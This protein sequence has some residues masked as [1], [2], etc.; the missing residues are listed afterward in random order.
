VAPPLAV[1]AAGSVKDASCGRHPLR[2]GDFEGARGRLAAR[3]GG[4]EGPGAPRSLPGCASLARTAAQH[5]TDS[6]PPS[7]RQRRSARRTGGLGPG[8]Q[9][10]RYIILER[11]A[12]AAWPRS[13]PRSTRTS[14]ARSAGRSC[15]PTCRRA[16]PHRGRSQLLAGPRR[17]HPLAPDVVARLRPSASSATGLDRHGVV[18]GVTSRPGSRRASRLARGAAEVRRAGR[19]ARPRTAPAGSTATS[20]RSTCSWQRRRLRVGGL[21][22]CALGGG[23]GPERAL[24]TDEPATA[25]QTT[26][27]PGRPRHVAEQH[28]GQV[29]LDARSDQY[30]FLHLALRGAPPLAPGV[31]GGTLPEDA[32]AG[33][34]PRVRS[35]AEVRRPAW[36]HRAVVAGSR[37]RPRDRYPSMD[38]LI[39]ELEKD[40]AIARRRALTVAVP[41]A[42]VCSARAPPCSSRG[43]GPSAAP[44]PWSAGPASGTTHGGGD[45]RGFTATG[46]PFAGAAADA[47]GALARRV[48][49]RLD[50]GLR[51]TC[52][53]TRVRGDQSE[54]LLDLKMQCWP[55][56]LGE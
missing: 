25:G 1:P 38:A 56:K 26:P 24:G 22:A 15:A 53:A 12:R 28:A 32:P 31:A 41:A 50:G 45:P 29:N 3:R 16:R 7:A 55:G 27:P 44:R 46:R 30:S 17:S 19:G 9:L 20:S 13:T 35:A 8:K 18:E 43:R 6:A 39:R 54:E 49:R 5:Q 36:L 4:G 40:P 23:A 51:D 47:V 11:S 52:L 42:L 10:G 33:A 2:P 34:H 21:R 14:G 37:L 48:P